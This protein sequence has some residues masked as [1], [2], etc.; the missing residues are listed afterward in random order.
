[1][2]SYKVFS[3]DASMAY[4]KYNMDSYV[5]QMHI[6]IATIHQRVPGKLLHPQIDV[7]I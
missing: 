3:N 7:Q 6:C 1:M 2:L 4:S 5:W